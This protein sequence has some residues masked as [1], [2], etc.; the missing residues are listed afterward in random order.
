MKKKPTPLEVKAFPKHRGIDPV[1]YIETYISRTE[2]VRGDIPQLF[3]TT[4]GETR[5]ISKDTARNWVRDILKRCDINVSQF[6]PGST[7]GASS[8]KASSM[9]ASLEEIL[10]AGEWS[11]ESTWQRYYNK[12]IIKKNKTVSDYLFA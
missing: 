5:P 6:G 9:G 8:S 7:R 10:K 12:P 3:L 4:K 11:N 1:H 2:G